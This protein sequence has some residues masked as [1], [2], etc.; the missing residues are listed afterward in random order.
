M[1][2]NVFAGC[3]CP[4]APL[5]GYTA[6]CTGTDPV[7]SGVSYYCNSGYTLVGS[8]YSRCQIGGY[9][10]TTKP[11]CQKSEYTSLESNSIQS[12][13]CLQLMQIVIIM[14]ITQCY[15]IEKVHI[16]TTNIK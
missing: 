5:N 10:S 2:P 6:S 13:N 14:N 4:R 11:T 16:S 15:L 8:S 9:W 7:W 12:M 1:L 3:L